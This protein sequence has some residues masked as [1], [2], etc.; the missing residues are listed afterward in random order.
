MK[1]VFTC[2]LNNSLHFL[3][4]NLLFILCQLIL[5]ICLEGIL[6]CFIFSWNWIF[7]FSMWNK[8]RLIEILFE[9]T[10]YS[11][12]LIAIFSLLFVKCQNAYK[13]LSSI[14]FIK[15]ANQN[16]RV[17]WSRKYGVWQFYKISLKSD[18]RSEVA[19]TKYL[20]LTDIFRGTPSIT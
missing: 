7:L 10:E 9:S 12:K 20:W 11:K 6:F 16:G 4:N 1:L 18:G 2:S 19:S 8:N 17:T 15:S 14:T 5:F 3:L 13:C